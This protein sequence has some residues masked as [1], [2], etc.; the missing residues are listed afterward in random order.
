MKKNI[1][2]YSIV[3]GLY[4][5]EQVF[6][7]YPD[8]DMNFYP[9]LKKVQAIYDS[10][11]AKSFDQK[12]VIVARMQGH[13]TYTKYIIQVEMPF[14]MYEECFEDEPGF[15]HTQEERQGFVNSMVFADEVNHQFD[16]IKDEL[17]E[18]KGGLS[19]LHITN[20]RQYKPELETA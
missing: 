2:L 5:Q 4:A 3:C 7:P 10:I 16:N 17:F 14:D 6:A 18:I 12:E 19:N 20:L 9:D 11:T 1:K 8:V 15:P 13:K